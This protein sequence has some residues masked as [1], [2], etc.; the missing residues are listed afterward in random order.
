MKAA[1]TVA[2]REIV[3]F[4]LSPLAYVVLAAW[5][6]L[7]GIQ[8]ALL[9]EFAAS[10]PFSTGSTGES[11]LTH[12][13]GETTLFYYLVLFIVPLFTMRLLSEESRTGTM[14][15][16]LTAPISETA[17]VLGKLLAAITFWLAL[18]VPTLVFVWLTSRYGRVDPWMIGATYLGVFMLGLSWM[19][20]GLMMSALA[21]NQ[22]V[23]FA[24]TFLAL[25]GQFM[26]GLGSFVFP[27]EGSRQIFELV[28]PWTH[29]GAYASG[30][31]DTRYLVFDLVVAAVATFLAIRA[32]ELRRYEG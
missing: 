28:S 17:V 24:L 1:W 3:S 21:R 4:F 30:M 19:S 16:L 11:P 2:K 6:A 15:T 9:C 13:F 7:Q 31:V 20:V 29:M 5:V 32:L 14:E 10:Q 22:M 8:F 18:W 25:A 12:F 27:G 26:A 23:A